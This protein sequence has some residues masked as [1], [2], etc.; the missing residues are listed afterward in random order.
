MPCPGFFDPL[1]PPLPPLPSLL[2]LSSLGTPFYFI[3]L[4][5]VDIPFALLPRRVCLICLFNFLGP[6]SFFF[7]SWRLG[8]SSQSNEGG[9]GDSEGPYVLFEIISMEDGIIPFP[10]PPRSI[11]GT[12]HGHEH[13]W[14]RDRDRYKLI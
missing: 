10:P 11:D 4:F 7:Y 5:S 6:P 8:R 13:M 12:G 3:I 9:W 2:V 14:I 1:P